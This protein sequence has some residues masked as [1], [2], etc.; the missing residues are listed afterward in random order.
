[1]AMGAGKTTVIA[2]LLALILANSQNL[3]IQVVPAALLPMSR[4]VV[5][6]AFSS[7]IIKRIYTIQFDRSRYFIYIYTHR[8]NHTAAFLFMFLA[9]G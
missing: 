1:M 7:I 9:R 5:R 3:V 4:D 8:A 2:P 6:D